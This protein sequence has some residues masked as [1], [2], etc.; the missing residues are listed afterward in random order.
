MTKREKTETKKEKVEKC[1][2][3]L[4]FHTSDEVGIDELGDVVSRWLSGNA[5]I[6]EDVL[7]IQTS[8][9]LVAEGASGEGIQTCVVTI[10][11]TEVHIRN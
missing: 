5:D 3:V 9:G 11:Y 7:G 8:I 2:Q 4:I 10:W 6:I 1:H